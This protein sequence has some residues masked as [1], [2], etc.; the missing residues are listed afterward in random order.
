MRFDD[1][2]VVI[3]G[4]AGGIVP[5]SFRI[6][7]QLLS[8]IE[9]EGNGRI[10]LDDLFVDIPEQRQQQAKLAAETLQDSVYLKYPWVASDST[11]AESHYELLL[12]NTWRP[13]VTI[14]GADG[15]P[16]L[17]DAVYEQFSGSKKSPHCGLDRKGDDCL[18]RDTE[19]A[20]GGLG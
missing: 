19:P 2:K 18:G 6:S 17:V 10:L 7:R 20:D 11:P 16:A 13:N 4:G 14:T 3:T 9:D 12:N 15:L 8:R 1:K 5:S